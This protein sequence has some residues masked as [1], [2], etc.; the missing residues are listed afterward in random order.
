MCWRIVPLLADVFAD[1]LECAAAAGGSATARFGFVVHLHEGS[2]VGSAARLGCWRGAASVSGAGASACSS[3]SMAAI[4][5][6][7]AS[8]SKLAYLRVTL[9]NLPV[10][11]SDSGHQSCDHF[12][13]LFSAQTCQ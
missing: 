8:S 13:Q 12:A 10:M 6:S 3:S 7:M 9:R 1:A 4:S 2:S 5:A 11:L